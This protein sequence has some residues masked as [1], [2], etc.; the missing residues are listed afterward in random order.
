MYD[1]KISA[2]VAPQD[3]HVPRSHL[4]ELDSEEVNIQVYL[5]AIMKMDLFTRII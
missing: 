1:V 4:I 3:N 2:I 5:Q